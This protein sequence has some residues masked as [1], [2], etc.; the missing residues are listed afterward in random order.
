[1]ANCVS[2]ILLLTWCQLWGFLQDPLWCHSGICLQTNGYIILFCE[3]PPLS[4]Q[5]AGKPIPNGP[6]PGQLRRL[7]SPLRFEGVYSGSLAGLLHLLYTLLDIY[8]MLKVFM[9]I[10]RMMCL[11]VCPKIGP[12][13]FPATSF[14]H[15]MDPCPHGSLTNSMAK[16]SIIRIQQNILM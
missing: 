3:T 11:V 1:M 2:F 7:S 9:A 14:P 15:L 13:F 10:S 6:C 16:Q 8:W 5:I 4:R 12:P